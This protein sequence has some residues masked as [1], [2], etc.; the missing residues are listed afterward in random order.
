MAVP[1]PSSGDKLSVGFPSPPHKT[2]SILVNDPPHINKIPGVH[3]V[4]EFLLT[5]CLCVT[6]L[7]LPFTITL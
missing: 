7:P 2:I 3:H 4:I 5:V 6:E 1:P